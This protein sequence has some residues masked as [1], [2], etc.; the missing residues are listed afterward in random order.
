MVTWEPEEAGVK[1][2]SKS[3]LA[4]N[5]FES[6]PAKKAD[7]LAQDE[8]VKNSKRGMLKSLIITS[9]IVILEVVIYLGWK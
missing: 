4:S 7:L 2:E 6:K 1:R 3:A 8:L 9:L 5:K